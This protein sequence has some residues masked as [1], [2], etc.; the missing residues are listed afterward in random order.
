[1]MFL[2]LR[3]QSER[4]MVLA[5]LPSVWIRAE[6]CFVACL[7]AVSVLLLNFGSVTSVPSMAR[8]TNLMAS[9]LESSEFSTL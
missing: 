7:V 9:I 6:N 1:M 3:L 8:F 4:V 2:G 5:C